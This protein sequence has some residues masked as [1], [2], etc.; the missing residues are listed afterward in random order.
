MKKIFLLL[1]VTTFISI[2]ACPTA[3][4]GTWKQD[5]VGWQWQEGNQKMNVSTWKWIDS[6]NDGLAECY[7]F[8]SDGYILTDTTIDGYTVDAS[9]AWTEDGVI[10]QRAATPS[11]SIAANQKGRELYQLGNQTNASLPG[12]NIDGRNEMSVDLDGFS[13]PVSIQTQLVYQNLNTPDMEFLYKYTMESMGSKE[14]T[15]KFYKDGYYYYSSY[16]DLKYKTK[17][18][19]DVIS[20]TLKLD[21]MSGQFGDYL[22]DVQIADDGNGGKILFYTCDF[23]SLSQYLTEIFKSTMPIPWDDY[24]VEQASGKAFLTPDNCFSKECV[25][26]RMSGTMEGHTIGMSMNIGIDYKNPGQPVTIEFPP[27]DDYQEVV[28]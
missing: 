25:S 21:G 7:Y 15:A 11:V 26:I 13:I 8:G 20:N 2:G 22:K 28:Y 4:A 19:A 24:K 5:S 12:L 27:T 10:R 17:I 6:N 1:A 9:G 3:F 18:G 14:T 16:N 23:E